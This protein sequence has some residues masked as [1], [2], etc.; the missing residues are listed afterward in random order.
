MKNLPN[1]FKLFF[2]TL[3]LLF[4]ETAFASSTTGDIKVPFGIRDYNVGIAPNFTLQD[5]D[6]ET[7]ELAK[8]KGNWIFLHFWAS[9][10]GPCKKE[11]PTIQKLADAMQGEKFKIIMVNTAEDEDT[12]FEFLS[13]IDVEVNTLMD[14]DGLVTEIWKPRGLPT[15]FLINPKGEVKYQAIGGREW[16]EPTYV[17]FLKKLLSS[18]SGHR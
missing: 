7:F 15:T 8:A 6:S 9:W 13:T 18:T 12:V 17:N 10:C 2:I 16:G 5:I 1:I 11:M 3:S 4:I 14:V